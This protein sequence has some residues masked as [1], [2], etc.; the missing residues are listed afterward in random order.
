MRAQHAAYRCAERFGIPLE[1]VN[2]EAAYLISSRDTVKK[3]YKL[4]CEYIELIKLAKANGKTRK[5]MLDFLR[6][7]E[8]SISVS[9]EVVNPVLDSDDDEWVE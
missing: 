4:M 3:N 2:R 9:E 5:E 6:G 7:E 8:P 1:E